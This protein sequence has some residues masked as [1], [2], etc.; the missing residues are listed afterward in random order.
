M[1][2]IY[3]YDQLYKIIMVGDS[4]V[5]KTSYLIRLTKNII[6]PTLPTIGVEYSS[7]IMLLENE[8][9]VIKATIWDTA[10][11]ERY[12]AITRAHY[13][14]SVGA[15]LFYDLT[16]RQSYE[17]TQSW[18]EDIIQYCGEQI[19][20]MLIG[21][22]SDIVTKDPKLRAVDLEQV[23]QYCDQK[24]LLYQETSALEGVNIK[25]S[26]EILLRRIYQVYL[27][28][29]SYQ[30]QSFI[31]SEISVEEKQP[32]VEQ[33]ESLPQPKEPIMLVHKPSHPPEISNC[34]LDY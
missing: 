27:D 4:N 28:Q 5:G 7:Q 2:N 13:R 26:F 8:N 1:Q 16:S 9:I 15:L 3:Q 25:E 22:K 21:N 32:Y 6:K 34:C 12:K 30:R 18:I 24:F 11:A 20:I 29:K 17:N 10:G 33:K 14:Q 19:P 23:H 31:V